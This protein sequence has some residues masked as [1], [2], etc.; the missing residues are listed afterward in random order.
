MRDVRGDGDGRAVRGVVDEP[1]QRE[2][3]GDGDGDGGGGGGCC[4]GDGDVRG[5]RFSGGLG[6]F[7]A[8]GRRG[9]S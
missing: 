9:K 4:D 7:V 2:R 8:C 5:V 6:A 1:A 3:V